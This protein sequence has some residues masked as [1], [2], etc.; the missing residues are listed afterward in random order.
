MLVKSLNKVSED[1]LI[2]V[3]FKGIDAKVPT[4]WCLEKIIIK[5]SN[6]NS[7]IKKVRY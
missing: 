4:L 6:A 1:I 7:N 5:T 2:I 3:R